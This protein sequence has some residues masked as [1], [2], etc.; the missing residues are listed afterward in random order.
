M[1]Q[2]S[3]REN[4]EIMRADFQNRYCN[5]FFLETDSSLEDVRI[6]NLT[7]DFTDYMRLIL[8]VTEDLM[9]LVHTA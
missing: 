2:W 4:C 5:Y 3:K 7:N 6:Y 9:W 8:Q 1:K